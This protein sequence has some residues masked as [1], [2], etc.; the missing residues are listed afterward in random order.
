MRRDIDDSTSKASIFAGAIE[1]G[2]ILAL[3]IC[4]MRLT[5]DIGRIADAMDKIVEEVGNG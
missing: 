4:A 2:M 3:F 5:H 1:F